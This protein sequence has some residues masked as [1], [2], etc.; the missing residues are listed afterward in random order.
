MKQ[1][2]E[3]VYIGYNNKKKKRKGNP[4]W[5]AFECNFTVTEL[6]LFESSREKDSQRAKRTCRKGNCWSNKEYDCC[7]GNFNSGPLRRVKFQAER[8]LARCIPFRHKGTGL[9]PA[10]RMRAKGPKQEN[11]MTVHLSSYSD[12]VFRFSN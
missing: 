6:R 8:L 1:A 12:K 2:T 11:D 5:L 9:A 7:G 10:G 4:S 3:K